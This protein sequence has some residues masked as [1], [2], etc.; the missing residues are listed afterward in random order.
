MLVN[1]FDKPK[2]K[3]K[4]RRKVVPKK[5]MKIVEERSKG[6]CEY[7]NSNKA[8]D[9]HHICEIGMGGGNR[10]DI[11]INILHVCRICHN[12]DNTKFLQDANNIL[13]QRVEKKFKLSGVLYPSVT[14]ALYARMTIDEVER[15]MEKGFLKVTNISPNWGKSSSKEDIMRWLGVA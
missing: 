3:A 2:K 1:T 5:V 12:H 15:Q 14:I 9:P 7:C 11:P 4:S 6:I 10:L 8:T 13:R